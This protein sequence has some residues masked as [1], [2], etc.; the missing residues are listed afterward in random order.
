MFVS[1]IAAQS[2]VGVCTCCAGSVVCEVHNPSAALGDSVLA[3]CSEL[4]HCIPA[5]GALVVEGGVV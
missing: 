4:L 5:A 2:T 3:Q 1:G